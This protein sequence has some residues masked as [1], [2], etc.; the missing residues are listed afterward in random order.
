MV[1]VQ[2]NDREAFIYPVPVDDA[3]FWSPLDRPVNRVAVL[4]ALG[5][6]AM[7]A[8]TTGDRLIGR[9]LQQLAT[10]TYTV[11]LY[12]ELGVMMARSRFIKR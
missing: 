10:G 3:L 11:L 2:R 12:D 8:A 7:E 6:V 5:R 4:D 9:P 1:A